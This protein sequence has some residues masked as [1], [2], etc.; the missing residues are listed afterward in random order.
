M[1]PAAEIKN[2]NVILVLVIASIDLWVKSINKL[3]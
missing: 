1:K 2:K 3:D